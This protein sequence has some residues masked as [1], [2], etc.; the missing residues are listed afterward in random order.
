MPPN[1]QLER[2]FIALLHETSEQLSI[3]GSLDFMWIEDTTQTPQERM[4]LCA[5]HEVDAPVKIASVDIEAARWATFSRLPRNAETTNLQ[6]RSASDGPKH[7]SPALRAC[8]ENDFL[9]HTS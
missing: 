9:P 6:A 2:F 3:A 5:G 4:K 8:T 1:E 7:S